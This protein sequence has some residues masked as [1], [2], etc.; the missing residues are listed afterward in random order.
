MLG[1]SEEAWQWSEQ[2][3]EAVERWL[4]E[5]PAEAFLRWDWPKH[6]VRLA[7]WQREVAKA[8]ELYLR[9]RL[10]V[11]R[12]LHDYWRAIAEDTEAQVRLACETYHEFQSVR[13]KLSD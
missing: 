6:E 13:A 4:R 1:G 11:L 2:F 10:E 5:P 8:R 9:E 7:G 12:W 3:L